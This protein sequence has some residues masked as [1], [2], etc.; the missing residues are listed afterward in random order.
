M[1]KV[2]VSA[3][4][5]LALSA[6]P[7]SAATIVLNNLGGVE[8]GT[9]AYKGFSIAADFW[10]KRLTNA[11]TIYFPFLASLRSSFLSSGAA[12]CLPADTGIAPFDS[13]S[14]LPLPLVSS[15][16]PLSWS[17]FMMNS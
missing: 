4:A 12:W 13:L 1:R 14:S 2:I 11:V 8:E 9:A 10:S 7:A 15:V 6:A 16:R 17:L 3:A 5:M